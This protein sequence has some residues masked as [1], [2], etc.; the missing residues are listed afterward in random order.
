M[1][2]D[3]R[4]DAEEARRADKGKY[5]LEEK[6]RGMQ[7]GRQD[8]TRWDAQGGDRQE[9]MREDARQDTKKDKPGETQKEPQMKRRIKGRRKCR[10]KLG[11]EGG[12]ATR[13]PR[14]S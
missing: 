6:H 14:E 5:P 3:T 1:L 10:R 13:Y 7:G 2:E 12:S 9:C 11:G 8:D 4:K